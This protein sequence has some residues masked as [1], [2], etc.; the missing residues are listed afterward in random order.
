MLFERFKARLSELFY[1]MWQARLSH[2]LLFTYP[3]FTIT[4]EGAPLTL[5][6][7]ST[8][9][10]QS[11]N[12]HPHTKPSPIMIPDSG[13]STCFS[14]SRRY[15]LSSFTSFFSC[16]E[17]SPSRG[18]ESRKSKAKKQQAKAFHSWMK[19]KKTHNIALSA[20]TKEFQDQGK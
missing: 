18:F 3:R 9:M 4:K 7:L 19:E 12:Y 5:C 14:L 16:I 20:Q 2:C 17:S 11:F 8:W 15:Q 13:F 10:K 1:I 6:V